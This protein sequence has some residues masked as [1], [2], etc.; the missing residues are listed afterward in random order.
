MLTP[1]AN[2]GYPLV[3]Q[4]DAL[5]PPRRVNDLAPKAFS[6]GN[7]GLLRVDK[8]SDRRNEHLAL[9]RKDLRRVD[10]PQRDR[11]GVRVFLPCSPNPLH[12]ALEVLVD[13]VLLDNSRQIVQY[14]C[15]RR[16]HLRE[17]GVWRE[18]VAVAESRDVYCASWV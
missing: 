4:V 14:L 2:N 9:L 7:A 12:A 1:I 3:R 5:I 16:E 17:I 18:G 13:A 11:P 15:L 8:P 10:V 6:A